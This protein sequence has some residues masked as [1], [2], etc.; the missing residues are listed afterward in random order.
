[1]AYEWVGYVTTAAVGLAGLAATVFTSNKARE[2]QERLFSEQL[3]Q[4]R[5]RDLYPE[6]LFRAKALLELAD[7]ETDVV[8]DGQRSR[9]QALKVEAQ[10]DAHGSLQTYILFARLSTHA[11]HALTTKL[12]LEIARKRQLAD[13]PGWDAIDQDQLVAEC[14]DSWEKASAVESSLRDQIR[15][16]LKT[17]PD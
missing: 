9:E 15:E 10:L 16:E 7:P 6:V 17:P 13:D 5:I 4:D 14:K 3:R 11:I 12:N 1:M 2:S 8:D